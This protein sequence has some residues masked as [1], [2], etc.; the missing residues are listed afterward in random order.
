MKK[1]NMEPIDFLSKEK[2]EEAFR[3][4]R[5]KKVNLFNEL[6]EVS[7]GV[8]DKLAVEDPSTKMDYKRLLSSSYV[9]GE[10][11]DVVLK[12][13]ERVGVLLPNSVIHVLTLFSLF[14]IGKT[15]AIFNFTMGVKT[16][17]DC[18]D[19]VNIK[20][21]ITSKAFIEK[22]R[23]EEL[24]IKLKKV[25][26][27]IYV[28]DIKNSI[29]QTDKAKAFVQYQVR[30]RAKSE[31][32][33]LILFTSGSEAKPKGVILTHENIY[34]NIYQIYSSM[35]FYPQDRFF[36]A[37]PM[38]HSFG[39]TI[40][41]LFPLLTKLSVFLYPS[42]LHFR[43]IPALV[44][45][46]HATFLFGT[47]TFLEKYEKYAK[48]YHFSTLRFAVA[49]AEQLKSEVRETYLRKHG[50]RILEGYGCTEASP[51]ISLNTPYLFKDGSVGVVLPGMEYK[52][53]PV[54]GI[55]EGG[56]LLVKGPNIMKGYLLHD[57]GFVPAPEWYDTGDIVKEDEEGFLY[58]LSRLKRFAKI[59][60]EMVSLNLVEQLASSCF[61]RTDFYA[62]SVPD[63]N[64]GERV[65]LFT[66]F[67]DIDEVAFKQFIKAK[68]LSPMYVPSTVHRIEEVPL[69][70]S[71]KV[72]Y[73]T[74]TEQAISL[75]KKK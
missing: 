32:N 72:D 35:A 52:I 53:Q 51:V 66:T 6:L 5:K 1:V 58:I 28:E 43:E 23:L 33:E 50:V 4:Y 26:R 13:Q 27:V 3:S 16:I 11:L 44:F 55:M 46:Q 22:S 41:T 62:V 71:G 73:V 12:E 15:P 24:V 36:N 40:G 47:S 74:L 31:R 25:V 64:K 9:F 70:G 45:K 68:Q 54:K 19:A 37:L 7:K 56:N 75:S 67:S 34:S 29:T 63:P 61:Q 48:P 30:N 18:V 14:R 59:A 21:L 49:G 17:L 60:G 8:E 69:L 38:F 2:K 65:V 10:K 20:S 57:K 39:L 42:P